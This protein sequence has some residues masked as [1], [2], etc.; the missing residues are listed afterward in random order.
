METIANLEEDL[1]LL[2]D[3]NCQE[4]LT[5]IQNDYKKLTGT[6]EPTLSRYVPFRMVYLALEAYHKIP[7]IS[8]GLIA[9]GKH[10]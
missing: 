3:E 10:I 2:K 1:P 4:K 8:P 5:L 7:N 6:V 9:I